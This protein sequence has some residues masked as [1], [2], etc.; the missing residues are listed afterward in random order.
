MSLLSVATEAKQ[1]TDDAA[2]FL[3]AF[4]LCLSRE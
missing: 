1:S 2:F 3:F 4:S